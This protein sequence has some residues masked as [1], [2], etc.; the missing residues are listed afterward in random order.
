[1]I[2]GNNIKDT[3]HSRIIINGTA[4]RRLRTRKGTMLI[5]LHMLEFKCIIFKDVYLTYRF[6][7]SLFNKDIRRL[8]SRDNSSTW[9]DICLDRSKN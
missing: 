5:I 9:Y 4:I 6:I 3:C 8:R 7:R 2:R 1:M